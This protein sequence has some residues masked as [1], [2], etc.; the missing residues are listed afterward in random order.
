MT[1]ARNSK[2]SRRTVAKGAAWS[3]PVVAMAAA[4][5]RAAASAAPPDAVR[6]GVRGSSGSITQTFKFTLDGIDAE[7]DEGAEYPA[8]TTLAFP[9]G[10]TYTAI[11]NGGVVA[12]ANP[13]IVEFPAGAIGVVRGKFSTK[14]TYTISAT[15]PGLPEASTTVTVS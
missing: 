15:G 1:D 3:A 12:Q 11:E 4:A 10:F 14:G 13:L 8:G 7:G 9:S 2:L 5:P 6:L